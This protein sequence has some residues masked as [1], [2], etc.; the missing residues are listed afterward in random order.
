M[1]LAGKFE[2]ST[3]MSARTFTYVNDVLRETVDMSFQI[4][5]GGG[6]P[7]SLVSTGSGIRSRTGHITFASDQVV[8]GAPSPLNGFGSWKPVVGDK[9]RVFAEVNGVQFPRFTGRVDSVEADFFYSP[10]ITV[11]VTD[12]LGD[13]LKRV[14]SVQ[15]TL[16]NDRATTGRVAY[17]AM[18]FAGLG[19]IPP[20][21][22]RCVIHN[23]MQY[24]FVPVIGKRGLSAGS[25]NGDSYG[26]VANTGGVTEIVGEDARAGEYVC[27]FGRA[28][29]NWDSGWRVN[30][31]DGSYLALMYLRGSETL[32]LS[33]S[34]SG[35]L[36]RGKWTGTKTLPYLAVLVAD[37][38]I[39]VWT[40]ERLEDSVLV[41]TRD[42]ANPLYPVSTIGTFLVGIDVRFSADVP[43][44]QNAI[45]NVL[46]F[47]LSYKKSALEK[48]TVSAFRGYENVPASKVVDDWC[49]AT[50]SSVWMDERGTPVAQ[51]RDRMVTGSSSRVVTLQ[52]KVFSGSW[53]VG[54]AGKR[55]RVVVKG[56]TP[57]L[58]GGGAD[59]TKANTIAY[60][61]NNIQEI[62]YNVEDVE[63]INV[64]D[65]EDWYGV[66]ATL[67]PVADLKRG[68][69]NTTYFNAPGTGSW[70]SI[71]YQND[72]NT[73]I[74]Q[75]T[76]S[77]DLQVRLEKLGQRTFKATH[78]VSGATGSGGTPKYFK[79]TATAPSTKL[80]FGARGVPTPIIKAYAV[81][82][83]AEYVLVGAYTAGDL[84]LQDYTLEA[85]WWL[86]QQDAQRYADALSSE[87]VNER[88]SF[89]GV[90][91][92]WD[93]TRQVGD[94][95]T[96]NFV[97]DSGRTRWTAQVLVT[98]YKEEWDE[99]GVPSQS[100]DAQVKSL[101]DPLAGKT[102]A[103]RSRAYSSYAQSAGSGKSYDAV[104]AALPGKV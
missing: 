9:V 16:A 84:S 60:Q 12:A 83:W 52:E 88:F 62:E 66:D 18:E 54:T 20:A 99:N 32:V 59:P 77:E 51:A 80:Y 13:Y 61:P 67:S 40:S 15:P 19:A 97:D 89:D 102:Y 36:W 14:V 92:L 28:S 91:V 42:F 101:V 75:W 10:F 71:V 37:P 48:Y 73:E 65:D 55:N 8:S 7:E 5:T 34:K 53:K 23:S 81:A 94:T 49:G 90:D 82:Q 46:E 26:V 21:G 25:E 96:W 17:T 11:G 87:L 98:G 50:L 3:V 33:S 104:Y 85:D 1:V 27:I 38:D 45:D 4:D 39:R 74:M 95:E 29:S 63:F 68:I 41:K 86:N 79:A 103:D 35:E 43:T 6:L 69:D 56:L 2:H 93:P 72:K 31:D 78:L 57:N 30:F 22:G 100:V 47:P 64:P 44:F 58:R 76:G 70:W 24:G